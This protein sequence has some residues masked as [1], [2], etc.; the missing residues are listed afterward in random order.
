[1]RVNE[2]YHCRYS[3]SCYF[4]F[5]TKYRRKCFS[6]AMLGPL[7]EVV[8]KLCEEWDAELIDLNGEEDHVRRSRWPRRRGWEW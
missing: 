8:A 4:V 1:M 7:K 6:G 5:V 2:L 3:L